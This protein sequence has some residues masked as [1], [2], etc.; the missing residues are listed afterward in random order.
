MYVYLLLPFLLPYPFLFSIFYR[1]MVN[2][3]EYS[4]TE[5]RPDSET[6]FL[7]CRTPLNERPRA[8]ILR[9]SRPARDVTWPARLERRAATVPDAASN[10]IR[11]HNVPSN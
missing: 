5:P 7:S 4:L 11:W 2:K 10:Q 1:I 3:D 8:P 9:G 6:K